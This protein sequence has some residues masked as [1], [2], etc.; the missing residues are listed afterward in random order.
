MADVSG[1]SATNRRGPTRRAPFHC[2][3]ATNHRVM[4][5][6]LRCA[7]LLFF[8]VRI[9][10]RSGTRDVDERCSMPVERCTEGSAHETRTSNC[11]HHFNDRPLRRAMIGH[12][13][14]THMTTSC[15]ARQ[16]P[17]SH[18][19]I[20]HSTVQTAPGLG[21]PPNAAKLY[22]QATSERQKCSSP[23]QVP[24]RPAAGREGGEQSGLRQNARGL[25]ILTRQFMQDRLI[26]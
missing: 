25:P 26:Y 17:S 20:V 7:L 21:A 22:L 13:P 15:S 6:N 1:K 9:C 14:H 18:L 11:T 12:R 24:F 5:A 4:P 23:P 8:P 2:G 10:I 19:A 16:R 3:F